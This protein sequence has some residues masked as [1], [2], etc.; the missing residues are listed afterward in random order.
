M[1]EEVVVILQL[2]LS[3]RKHE[4]LMQVFLMH[5]PH[6]YGFRSHQQ[7][8]GLDTRMMMSSL[9]VGKAAQISRCH[10]EV[11]SASTSMCS[12]SAKA[13]VDGLLGSEWVLGADY[14]DVPMYHDISA[15]GYLIYN[16][17]RHEDVQIQGE[18]FNFVKLDALPSPEEANS[19]EWRTIDLM[20]HYG[21]CKYG[22]WMEL[23]CLRQAFCNGELKEDLMTDLAS[24]YGN[25]ETQTLLA[26]ALDPNYI[27]A[28]PDPSNDVV[29]NY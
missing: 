13:I 22:P 20:N 10:I 28:V 15:N 12:E 8:I 7:E 16:K 9:K 27:L 24:R 18:R 26:K 5:R 19:V 4:G 11:A 29:Y 23:Y 6:S 14:F 1:I 25:K 17:H 3:N 21:R 2:E